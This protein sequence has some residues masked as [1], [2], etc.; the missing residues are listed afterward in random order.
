MKA[1]HTIMSSNQLI[2]KGTRICEECQSDVPIIERNGVE[3]SVCLTCENKALE[4]DVS[5]FKK[6]MDN[7]RAEKLF[8]RYS[9]IPSD[10]KKAS[11]DSYIPKHQLQEDALKIAK[12]YAENFNIITEDYKW[13][14][15]LLKGSYGV[16]KSHLSHA[17]ANSVK[18]KGYNV[19]FIDT[20]SLFQ[21]I[22]D[23]FGKSKRMDRMRDDIYETE[24]FRMIADV[25]L[26]VLDDIGT[27]YVKNEDG[28][29]SWGSE[30]IFRITNSRMDKPKIFTTNC[31]S[32]ELT[33]KYGA[34]GGRIVSRMMNKTRKVDIDGDDY[35][36]RKGW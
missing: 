21:M 12:W 28:R 5:D 29:E 17:I 35:R 30:I 11:F 33:A 27:E 31:D 6:Q 36:L 8:E 20:P 26:L 9:L 3:H 4:K 23:S 22:R 32:R 2:H 16:G 15:L 10:L 14:S 24:I 1:L 19:L 34:H 13:N 18:E 7:K 25:D